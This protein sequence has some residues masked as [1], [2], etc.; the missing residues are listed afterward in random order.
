MLDTMTENKTS[1]R[2]PWKP[3]LLNGVALWIVC[4]ASREML[5]LIRSG[6]LSIIIFK[7]VFASIA[8]GFLIGVSL[9]YQMLIFHLFKKRI[10][11]ALSWWILF[12]LPSMA[13]GSVSFYYAIPSVQARVILSHAEL[14]HLPKSAH[15][16][17][18]YTWAS[19]MSGE[20]FLKF[21]ASRDDIELF[22]AASP[23][24][25]G[26]KCVNYTKDKMRLPYPRD[27]GTK[28]EHF[29]TPHEYFSL[30]GAPDWYKVELKGAGRRYGIHPEGYHYPG[31][32]IIDDESGIVYVRLIFS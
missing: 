27:F 10:G 30:P 25:K 16:I 32:V 26:K 15:D 3:C 5:E 20:E 11:R 2:F 23:T 21:K 4:L 24:L 22:L 31:E 29:N 17:K 14:A 28:E 6:A 13:I 19:P 8:T 9:G 7:A 1:M 12:L 18:V